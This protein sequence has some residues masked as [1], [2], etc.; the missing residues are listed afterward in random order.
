MERSMIPTFLPPVEKVLLQEIEVMLM[1]EAPQLV[2]KSG[3]AIALPQSVHEALRCLVSVMLAG[4]SVSIVAQ[5]KY[6]S[7]QQAAEILGCSRPHLYSLLDQGVLTFIKVGRHRRLDLA[8]VVAYKMGRSSEQQQS[9][10]E[11]ANLI[12]KLGLN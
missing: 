1:A 6:L 7:C 5:P 9:L 11:L 4:Q 2:D 10:L 8:D 3:R 12:K